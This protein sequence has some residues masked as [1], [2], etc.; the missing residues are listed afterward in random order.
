M[1]KFFSTLFV[2]LMLTVTAVSPAFAFGPM[3]VGP[4]PIGPTPESESEGCLYAN[5]TV[6]HAT[7]IPLGNGVEL[8]CNNG[9][10][11]V[12]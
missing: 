1:K 8:V 3:P 6:K 10:W 9:T 12:W 2:A 4:M 11:E 5:T 7:I